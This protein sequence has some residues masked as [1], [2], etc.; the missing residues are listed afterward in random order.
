M[1]QSHLYQKIVESIRDDIL[2]G[3]IKPGAS[4]PPMRK[5]TEKWNCTTGTIMRAYQELAHQGLIVSHVGKGTKV[6]E[7]L[8]E[9]NQSPLRRASLFNRTEA[10]L[11]EIITAGYTPDEVEQS[12]RTALDR[13]K[14][15]STQHEESPSQYFALYSEAMIHLWPRLRLAITKPTLNFRFICLSM[16]ALANSLRWLKKMLILQVAIYGMKRLTPT[17]SHLFASYCQDK[18]SLAHIGS[19]SC[20]VDTLAR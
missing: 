11:L 20:G 10:F 9:Q 5:M 17:M 4:L 16:E 18:S 8:S 1:D 2:S 3:N 14:T 7:N 12:V 13:W 6:V 19:P 15:F